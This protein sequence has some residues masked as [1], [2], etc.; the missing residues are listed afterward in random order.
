MKQ[1]SGNFEK[2]KSI[3]VPWS[4]TTVFIVGFIIAAVASAIGYSERETRQDEALKKCN[5]DMILKDLDTIKIELR[6]INN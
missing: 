4:W 1:Q 3:F 5:Y 6:N 2:C